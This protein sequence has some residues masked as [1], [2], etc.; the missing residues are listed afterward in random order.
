MG[1]PRNESPR[2]RAPMDT[3]P[4]TWNQ[5]NWD[6]CEKN[7]R[8]LQMRIAKA[9]RE[10]K[11]ARAHYLQRL[12]TRSYAAKC[13]AVKRVTENRGKNFEGETLGS[14][15][16]FS[17]EERTGRRW[18]SPTRMPVFSGSYSQRTRKSMIPRRRNT[19]KVV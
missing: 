2:S 9:F 16:S 12:L 1:T 19:R 15:T 13:L 18:P 4:Q 3:N 7:V 10:G 14:P 6:R 5:I 11:V 17:D 8:K